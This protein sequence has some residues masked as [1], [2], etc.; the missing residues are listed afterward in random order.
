M[1][2]TSDSHQNAATPA[3]DAG[4]VAEAFQRTAER[5]SDAIA[6]RTRER[7]LSWREYAAAVRS[8]AARLSGLGIGRG[9]TVAFMAANRPEFNI[10][11]AAAMHLGAICFS[12]YNTSAPEQVAAVLADAGNPVLVTEPAL[13]E[14]ARAGAA[15]SRVLLFEELAALPED[16]DLDYDA[17]WRA[18]RPDDLVC[19]I[20]TSGTTGPPKG[21]E[22][23]HANVMAGLRGEQAVIGWRP[24]DQ[25]VSALPHAHVGDRVMLHYEAMLEGLEVILCPDPRQMLEYVRDFRPTVFGGVPRHY[26]KLKA[27]LEASFLEGGEPESRARARRALGAGIDRVRAEQRGEPVSEDVLVACREAEDAVFRP[28]REAIGL[29]RVRN[30]NQSG[31]A[32][33]AIEVL[34]FFAAIGVGIIELWGM[35]EV[36]CAAIVNPPGAARFGTVGKVLPGAEL[37]VAD[38]GELEIRGPSVMRG[39]RNLPEA[40]REAFTEDA[41]LRTGDIARIDADGHV[42]I[43]DRKK[44]LI[45]N[46][47][48]KNMS[49]ANIERCLKEASALVGQAYAHGDRRPYNVALIVLDP[50]VARVW[51]GDVDEEIGAAVERANRR[52][53]RVEQIKRWARLDE[54]WLPGGD[55][56]TPTAKLKRRPIA[57]KYAAVLESLYREP[58]QDGPPSGTASL[59][60]AT[61]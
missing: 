53:S 60:A 27:A 33:A 2:S 1:T 3:R 56:L 49:P 9:S 16:L 19:L 7:T 13:A 11:D 37:R 22:L 15:E 51:T 44:E 54:E 5:R 41:W 47:A 29:D 14:R 38:D 30:N 21:V 58:V 6:L 39:Y 23:S 57:E 28:M 17:A 31:A 36:S 59:R 48:G 32:P 50:E 25:V 12:I 24:G 10:T 52:L 8:M 43:V 46:A 4:T 40:T 35:S 45:I 20:Y 34:E 42:T 61:A 26:E 55:E 18:I